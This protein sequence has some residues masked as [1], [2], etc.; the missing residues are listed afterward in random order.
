[1]E[2]KEKKVRLLSSM[3]NLKS[4][5]I[6]WINWYDKLSSRY[7]RRDAASI[8]LAAWR[9]RGS[10]EA[11]T[12]DLRDRLN[13]DGIKISENVF[14]EIADKG[15]S[16]SDAFGNMMKIGKYTAFAVGGILILG[17]GFAVYNISKNASSLV[18]GGIKK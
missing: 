16:I 5:D 10:K 13:D 14:Q 15:D 1:M 3:P 9:K 17:L 4:K 12:T 18:A 2:I 11:N 8:F 6:E 7:G